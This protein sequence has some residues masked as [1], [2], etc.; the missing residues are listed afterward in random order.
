[1]TTFSPKIELLMGGSWRDLTSHVAGA[2]AVSIDRGRKS[3]GST[4]EPTVCRFTLLDDDRHGAGNYS[5]RNPAGTYYG[6]LT[7][8]VQCRVSLPAASTRLFLMPATNS[9][10][11]TPDSA[12]LSITGD[13]DLRADIFM[14]NWT[15]T[16][17]SAVYKSSTYRL[18]VTQGRV[19][20]QWWSDV[21]TS[22]NITSTDVVPTAGPGRLSIRA[23]LDVDNGAGGHTVT[24]YTSTTA[25]TAGAWTQLGD[26]VV[27]T[28]TTAIYDSTASLF[29]FSGTASTGI[30]QSLECFSLA[31]YQGIAG[32]LRANPVFSSQTPGASSFADAQG[33][34]WTVSAN[35][36]LTDRDYR[37]WG[38]VMEITTDED[39]TGKARSTQIVAADPM[40]RILA[41]TAPSES[42]MSRGIR[43]LTTVVG[44]WPGEDGPDATNLASGL[45]SQRAMAIYG[46]PDMASSSDLFPGAGSLMTMGDATRMRTYGFKTYTNTGETQ[47]RFLLAMEGSLVDG[48]TIIRLFTTGTAKRWDLVARNTGALEMRAYD[49]DNAQI[50]ASGPIA[51][52]IND[53]HVWLSLEYTQDGADVDW[54][55]ATLVPG[56]TI[57]AVFGST[58]AGYTFGIITNIY[59]NWDLNDFSGVTFGQLLV[60]NDVTGLFDLS[61]QLNGNTSEYVDQRLARML[62][63]EEGFAVD[64]VGSTDD[65]DDAQLGYQTIAPLSESIRE[66][67]TQDLGFLLGARN[68]Y[69]M[70]YRSRDSLYNQDAVVSLVYAAPA[71]DV[72]DLASTEDDRATAN[73]VTVTRIGGA[74]SRAIDDFSPMGINDPTETPAGVGLYRVESSISLDEDR[75]ARNHAGWRLH[76]GT[77]NEPRWLRVEVW[78]ERSEVSDVLPQLRMVDVGDRITVSSVP[79][80]RLFWDIDA[81]VI[82]YTETISKYEWHLSFVTIPERAWRV[83]QVS[84]GRRWSPEDSALN[85]SLNSSATSFAVKTNSGALWTTVDVPLDILVGGERMTVGAISGSSSPQ[86]FSSVTRAVNGVTKSHS[87]D[88]AVELWDPSYWPL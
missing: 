31:V 29:C 24:F 35:A 55:I 39:S 82:G 70:H 10:A 63:L 65:V 77:V 57:G 60:Q 5:P 13:I 61:K 1:M 12:G 25:G 59:V 28:G 3:E 54:N 62:N 67:E 22:H 56:A 64:F 75:Q 43:E 79:T 52:G 73:D 87:A 33:N 44:W 9:H 16:G 53:N 38:E 7:R 47:V 78:G 30:G 19:R 76:L 26:P 14:K 42:P 41:G 34:T 32:T 18:G 4:T 21:S 81:L 11:S 40:R 6:Q 46:D 8:G 74:S 84:A 15:S 68:F 2:A 72:R 88:A 51:F 37:F 58:V 23:T 50:H 86:T 20:L 49:Q 71:S 85:A 66:C 83:G 36:A 27:T 69:G 80:R 17:S 45:E 48:V